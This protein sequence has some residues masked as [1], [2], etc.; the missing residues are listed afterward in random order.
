NCGFFAGDAALSANLREGDHCRAL[1]NAIVAALAPGARFELRDSEVSGTGDCLIV[2]EG[3]DTAAEVILA[4]TRLHGSPRFTD[5]SE[6]PCGFYAHQSDARITREH[7]DFRD[8][9]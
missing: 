9:R 6:L 7:L 2:A 8:T 1:G 3:G 5:P 4:N